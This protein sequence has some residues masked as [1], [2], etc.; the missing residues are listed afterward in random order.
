MK[1][2]TV[3]R[4]LAALCL[5]LTALA[6]APQ[7]A[8]AQTF[9][10]EIVYIDGSG[11]IRV[12]D[13]SPIGSRPAVT[14]FSPVGGYTAAALVDANR[15]GDL[16]I[17]ALRSGAGAYRLDIYDP[18]VTRAPLVPG[19]S[20]GG[21]PWALLYSLPLENQPALIA[22]GNLDATVAGDEI[23]FSLREQRLVDGT[24]RWR[25]DLYFLRR[26]GSGD[27]RAWER[28]SLAIASNDWTSVALG[29]MDRNGLDEVGLASR[30]DGVLHI[31]RVG[32]GG[33]AELL[34]K[35]E[36]EDRPWQH[37]AMGQWR[38]DGRDMLGA[39]R[40]A[41]V[42]IPAFIIF[43]FSASI[44]GISDD[45]TEALAPYPT[46]IFFGDVNASGDDEAF[47][48]RSVPIS[49][50][51]SAR[52]FSRNRNSDTLG[53]LEDRLT[54][55]NGYQVGAA[56][57]IDG[58][59]RDE[60]VLMRP[61]RFRTYLT[62]DT[63]ATFTEDIATTDGRTI[64][65]GDLD[66]NGF[67]QEVVLNATPNPAT[68]AARAGSIATP[69]TVQ[70]S[71]ATNAQ[72]IEFGIAVESN[73]PWLAFQ[74]NRSVTPA[75]I[76]LTCDATTL[77]PG[78]Y[79]ARLLV[80]SPNPL[81]LDQPLAVD[82]QF[83]VT[84]GLVLRPPALAFVQYPCGVGDNIQSQ[85]VEL[86]APQ[87]TAYTVSLVQ[88]APRRHWSRSRRHLAVER[89]VGHCHIANR[90]RARNPDHHRG[91]QQ[92]PAGQHLRRGARRDHR[93]GRQHTAGAHAAHHPALRVVPGAAAL[94]LH[95]ALSRAHSPTTTVP[96]RSR[97]PSA[98]R[99]LRR[100]PAAQRRPAGRR[101]T[102]RHTRRAAAPQAH[103]P[104]TDRARAG[105]PAMPSSAR[106]A[107]RPPEPPAPHRA[108]Y[109]RRLL[110][111][112]TG[113]AFSPGSASHSS[114]T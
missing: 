106:Q 11:V 45:Y 5:A 43:R 25:Q 4:W 87:G 54:D 112:P 38:G 113:S 55:D 10:E 46:Y 92:A 20:I 78:I 8:R 36:S 90:H 32:T 76:T 37:V 109:R 9:D 70:L 107:P 50:T 56:G 29:E 2:F 14:W 114:V 67:V 85:T 64:V 17:A 6:A 15:D 30:S 80:T 19:Q 79:S 40:R 104:P 108:S 39:V 88:A 52:L 99:A 72:P 48:L 102:R 3:W 93:H 63:S 95:A 51:V 35:N 84:N 47:L 81:V 49:N 16:E 24:L 57:D 77:V 82:V 13:P 66:R 110:L 7:P 1:R 91:L 101:S 23:F 103:P 59:G 62:P 96:N 60:V 100:R 97:W 65:I 22:A 74:V 44:D 75:T 68:C 26:A 58:D 94:R 71:N 86:I 61:D 21:I 53:L 28:V 89:A 18:V 12:R 69:V 27:G 34:Y 33:Y 83:A 31:W 73:A 41:P 105:L 111:S 98:A 42:S